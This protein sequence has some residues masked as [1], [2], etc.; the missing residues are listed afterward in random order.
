M[1]RSINLWECL[2]SLE[3]IHRRDKYCSPRV[4]DEDIS[5]LSLSSRYYGQELSVQATDEGWLIKVFSCYSDGCP[6]G[7]EILIPKDRLQ[8]AKILL[9][10]FG[11]TQYHH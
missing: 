4:M 9:D 10:R 3:S 8:P 5:A 11:N 6:E 1:N 2:T 7:I